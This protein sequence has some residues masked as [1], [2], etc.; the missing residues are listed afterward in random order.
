MRDVNVNSVRAI[1]RAIDLLNVFSVEHPVLTIDEIV[2]K[3]K[4]PKTT[5]Y[6]ILYT[7]ELRGLIQYDQKNQNYR[8]GL[9]LLEY[10][11]T[12]TTLLDV[13]QEA[14]EILINLQ[15]NTKQ[16]VI[17]AVIEQETF[18][19]VFLRENPVG[20]KYSSYIGLRR[21]I[22]FG[23]LGQV[24]MAHL[25]EDE[26]ERLLQKHPLVRMTSKTVTDLDVLRVRFK[27]IKEERVYA[28][29]EETY[30]G[31]IAIGAPIYDAEG[32][33]IAALA[34]LG[35]AVQLDGDRLEPAKLMVKEAASQISLKMGF[36]EAF[37]GVRL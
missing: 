25:T 5:A 29:M 7:L 32:K 34:I 3:T 16:T 8:L 18:V 6:R 15:T 27:K 1:D 21:P 20:F 2:A 24:I 35:P 30:E 28:D 33:L 12:L 31:G 9:K 19:Y 4:L 26:L 10:A 22:N 13:R 36:K 37:G 14:E 11:G 17:M 23:V